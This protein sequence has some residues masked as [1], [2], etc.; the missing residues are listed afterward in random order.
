MK[1]KGS[2]NEQ[3]FSKGK[4]V[5]DNFDSSVDHLTSGQTHGWKED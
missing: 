4:L 2:E 3:D 5:E 1:Q